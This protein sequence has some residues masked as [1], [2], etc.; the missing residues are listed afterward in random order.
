MNRLVPF[1]V[2]ASGNP[3]DHILPHELPA[4]FGL[5]HHVTNHVLM[6]AA[7]A[8]LMLLVFP[9]IARAKG[10][11][12]TGLR[13]ALEALLQ[14]IR[15][16]V[17]RPALRDATDRFIPFLWTAFFL[18]LFANLIGMLPI[19]AAITAATGKQQ[20][21]HFGGTATGN[22]SITA[23]LALS[24][25]LLIHLGGMKEQGVVHYWKS[26]VPHVPK[27]LY[28]LMLVLELIGSLVKPFA[29]AIRL[30]ANMIAGH[31]VLAVLI[32][33]MG[34]LA[35][36]IS[37]LGVGV[38]IASILGATF[39]SLLELLVAFL[40]AYIFTYLTALF[41]GMAVHPEH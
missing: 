31:I 36:G 41:I 37:G 18:V 5:G 6:F 12:P 33:F 2:L 19:D 24:S 35:S 23:G 17:A 3:L 32:G 20:P 11:V 30:F 1:G 9:W 16:T 14:F 13:N 8:L 40:Q 26:F 7:A 25:F 21:W 38:A 39:I 22:L 27:A 15:E 10:A 34:V 29:L 4:S 28:P